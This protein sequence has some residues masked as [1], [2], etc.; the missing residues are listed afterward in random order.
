MWTPDGSVAPAL[1]KWDY[2]SPC[3]LESSLGL[4]RA[5]ASSLELIAPS[6]WETVDGYVLI[7]NRSA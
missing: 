4:P 5:V 7:R 1:E 6:T 3:Y 2:H